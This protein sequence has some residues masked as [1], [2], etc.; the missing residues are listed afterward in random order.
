MRLTKFLR[1]Y[2][3]ANMP[4]KYVRREMFQGTVYEHS[5]FLQKPLVVNFNRDPW[6]HTTHAPWT[7]LGKRINQIGRRRNE[8]IIRPIVD[9]QIFRGDFVQIL[10][11]PDKGK[12]GVV[13]AVLK[14]RNWVFVKGLNCTY[15]SMKMPDGKINYSK[16]ENPL[17]VIDGVSLIDPGTKEP[18]EIEWRFL[19]TGKRVRVSKISERI[20]QLPETRFET[21]DF[22]SPRLYKDG[23][24][25]TSNDE[26]KEVTFETKL[27]TVEEDLMEEY[28]IVENRKR[29]KTFIY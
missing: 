15:K 6:R 3:Y 10:Q 11:G 19:E 21:K 16:V 9:W 14:E 5:H 23:K 25:D 22:K 18:C 12:Q 1:Y 17:D 2:D 26:I 8:L 13:I 4:K 20:I 27:K 29:A 7:T 24:Y 28:G